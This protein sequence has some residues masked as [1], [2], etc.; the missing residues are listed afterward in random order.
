[1][2]IKEL[3]EKVNSIIFLLDSPRKELQEFAKELIEIANLET[4]T[5]AKIKG[6][7]K[8]LELCFCE[9][10]AEDFGKACRFLAILKRDYEEEFL[11]IK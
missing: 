4:P 8:A 1:M 9:K 2:D 10:M 5:Q 11:K 3:R 7:A 6:K